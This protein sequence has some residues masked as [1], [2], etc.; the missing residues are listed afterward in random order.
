MPTG[1]I[2]MLAVKFPGN[3][4][5]GEIAPALADLIES[6]TI[7]VIDIL[8]VRKDADGMVEISEISELD[9]ETYAQFDLV[10]SDME[11][12]MSDD[13]GRRMSELLEP[14]SSAAVMVFENTWATRFTEAM[15]HADGEVVFNERIPRVVIDEMM[16]EMDANA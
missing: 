5:T 11:G 4:F 12:L 6:G 3:K 16:A 2:E 13:D 1:P 7:R 14:D 8:F 9:D 15:R 10:T